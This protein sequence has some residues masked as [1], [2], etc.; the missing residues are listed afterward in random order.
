MNVA[1]KLIF[2]KKQLQEIIFFLSQE[3]KKALAQPPDLHKMTLSTF[4]MTI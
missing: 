2:L 3:A 4:L 1:C